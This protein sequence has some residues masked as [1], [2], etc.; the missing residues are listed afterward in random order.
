MM[1][2]FRASRGISQAELAR[3]LTALGV[4][5]DD[6]AVTRMERGTRTIT[7]NE[8]VTIAA[9]LDVPV[10]SLLRETPMPEVALQIAQQEA[11]D[12]SR[13]AAV[14]A[15]ELDAAR[16][17]VE[18]LAAEVGVEPWLRRDGDG[19]AVPIPGAPS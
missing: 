17:R 5:V 4:K 2:F 19:R 13:Q 3:Q 14:V 16:S 12:L 7:V 6:S 10:P 8:L 11:A 9:A 18:R 15:T 1:K